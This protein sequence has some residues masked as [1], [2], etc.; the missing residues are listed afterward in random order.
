MTGVSGIARKCAYK[1]SWVGLLYQ[2]AT[3]STASAPASRA[4]CEYSIAAAVELLPAPAITRA[5]PRA[6]SIVSAITLWSSAS[7]I[8]ALSPV[9][10]HG[11]SRRTPPVIWRSTSARI[12]SSSIAPP[13]VNGVTSAVA[14][15]RIQSTFI[16]MIQTPYFYGT[17]SEIRFVCS[18]VRSTMFIAS[19]ISSAKAPEERN[20]N[21]PL[22]EVAKTNLEFPR[23]YRHFAPNGASFP[24]C[25]QRPRKT[26]THPSDQQST[27]PRPEPRQRNPHDYGR[28]A[29]SISDRP[30]NQSRAGAFRECNPRGST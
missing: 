4:R 22:L 15:P 20:V 13:A 21:L 30:P 27:S 14:Q 23:D 9:V 12:R 7:V 16:V 11:T 10:P 19:S 5:R 1:P 29:R 28:H 6:T 25:H 2:G 26:R 3:C 24:E 8:V 18:S 17:I